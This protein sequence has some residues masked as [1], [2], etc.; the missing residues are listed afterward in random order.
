[1]PVAMGLPL[2]GIQEQ[3]LFSP[4]VQEVFT[5][6]P[7]IKGGYMYANDRPGWG[8]D[9]N[10]AAAAKFPYTSNGGSRGNDRRLDGTVV[11]P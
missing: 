7:V 8:I 2:L 4:A 11:R 6:A 5:G 3:N 10:E 1:M 9:L